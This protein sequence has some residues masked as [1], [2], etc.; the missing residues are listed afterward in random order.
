MSDIRDITLDRVIKKIK[1]KNPFLTNKEIA[2]F[3]DTGLKFKESQTNSHQLRKAFVVQ[4]IHS[5]LNKVGT[6]GKGP[7][8]KR[9]LIRNYLNSKNYKFQ[10]RV[11]QQK[12]SHKVGN[13]E[14]LFSTEKGK[15]ILKI[16]KKKRKPIPFS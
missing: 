10:C 1:L 16:W 12:P 7:H 3:L 9:A 14:K 15:Q 11:F 13:V 6:K 8:T 2:K 5:V 4:I